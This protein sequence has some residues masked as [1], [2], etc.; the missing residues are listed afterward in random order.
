VSPTARGAAAPFDPTNI[1]FIVMPTPNADGQSHHDLKR[2]VEH[3]RRLGPV[4]DRLEAEALRSDNQEWAVALLG[5][6]VDRLRAA[7]P[8]GPTSG[9]VEMQRQFMRLASQARYSGPR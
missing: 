9:M 4:L 8:P 6:E 3:W 5:L 1:R 2:F 7:D